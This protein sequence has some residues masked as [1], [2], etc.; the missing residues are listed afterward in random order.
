MFL[1]TGLVLARRGGF[2]SKLLLPFKLGLGG[3]LGTGEQ[4]M[5]WLT[6]EDMVEACCFL[7]ERD[8]VQGPSV[9]RKHY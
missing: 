1:R 5:S 6:L 4:V 3:R 7:L 2:L 9:R 8:F